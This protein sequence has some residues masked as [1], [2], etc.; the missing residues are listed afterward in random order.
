M[1]LV[2]GIVY[3]VSTFSQ[4]KYTYFKPTPEFYINDKAEVLTQ[5]TKWTIYNNSRMLYEDSKDEEYPEDIRGA[6]V[7][8]VTYKTD[9]EFLSTTLFNEMK[10]GENDMGLLIVLLFDSE[11]NFK[12]VIY[13]IGGKMMGYFT[14]TDAGILIADHFNA[15]YDFEMGLG[16]MYFETIKLIYNNAYDVNL[17]Y[18]MEQFEYDMYNTVDLLPSE[19]T[20]YGSWFEAILVGNLPPWLNI[21]LIVL[22]GLGLTGTIGF[23]IFSS[24]SGGGGRSIGYWLG[25]KK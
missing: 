15:Y 21:V 10:I 11:S 22:M 4:P 6:Q 5:G 12:E 25:K 16:E 13:D 3:L 18:D 9:Q 23:G 19:R 14:A 20:Y 2:A 24:T 1:L 8:V 17:T 7:V